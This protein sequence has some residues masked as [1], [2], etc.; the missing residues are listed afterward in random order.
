MGPF[1]AA[2]AAAHAAV[3]E[4]DD[5]ERH[6]EAFA[7]ERRA[8]SD[9]IADGSSSTDP[10]QSPPRERNARS[11][12]SR[13]RVRAHPCRVSHDPDRPANL[14]HIGR[15]RPAHDRCSS[16]SARTASSSPPSIQSVTSS[17][18]STHRTCGSIIGPPDPLAHVVLQRRTD[19]GAGPVQQ[20]TLIRL[21][22]PEQVARLFRGEP[23]HVAQRDDQALVRGQRGDHGVDLSRAS[24]A[25]TSRSGTCVTASSDSHHPAHRPG[26]RNGPGR[27]PVDRPPAT[28][29]D[30]ARLPSSP[31]HGPVDHDAEH[32]RLQRGPALE[33]VEPL[34]HAEPRIL[35]DVLRRLPARHVGANARTIDEWYRS[36]R[37]ASACSSPSRNAAINCASSP[38]TTEPH[39]T[40]PRRSPYEAP[41]VVIATLGR[42][43]RRAPE[44]RSSR[45]TVP[46]DRAHVRQPDSP[47]PDLPAIGSPRLEALA[48][49]GIRRSSRSASFGPLISWRCTVSVPRPS[50]CCVQR[51]L[52]A[53]RRSGTTP[54][55][56][57]YPM[58]CGRMSARWISR[59]VGS[60]T[61]SR[62]SS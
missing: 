44:L 32:P 56:N 21:A 35:H 15:A 57:V 29:R 4:E 20:D 18:S 59:I 24:L 1:V 27:P 43:V 25:S 48:A 2:C 54:S 36:T 30:V 23:L 13:A 46:P 52:I 8:Q 14:R 22:D 34:D 9:W 49:A 51:S 7:A 50:P 16:T 62:T 47:P 38:V 45:P 55:G 31:R 5:N 26:A 41:A 6:A 39:S 61:D 58:M 12:P 3:R 19:P 60:S 53:V 37:W 42:H 40:P 11:S 28:R 33:P 17:T 10:L